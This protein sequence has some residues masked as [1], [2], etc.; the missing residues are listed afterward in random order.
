M[1]ARQVAQFAL[2]GV[3]T[4]AVVGLGT[5]IAARR[6]G[7]REAITEARATTVARAQGL[8][9]PVLTDGILTGDPDAFARVATVVRAGILD[10]SLVRV[11][12]WTGAGRIVYSDEPRLVGAT[13]RLGEDDLA[14]LRTGAIEAQVS[15]LT[16][17]ENRFER[18]F[19]RLLEVYLPVETPS[20][21]PLLFEA[22]YR[23]D[24]VVSSGARLFRAFA[25]I[26][27]GALVLLQL[28]QVPLAW[29]LARRL[30]RRVNERE[31]LLQRTLDAADVER[32]QIAS[33]LHDGVVQDLAGVAF[34]LSGASRQLAGD[35][36]LRAELLETAAEQVRGNIQALRSLLV[37]IYPPNLQDEGLETALTDLL[38]AVRTRGIRAELDASAFRVAVAPGV[39]Q[40]LYRGAQ[41]ALRNVVR[42]ADAT[43]VHVR[44]AAV[45]GS[46]RVEVTDDGRGFDREQAAARATEGH[47]GLRSLAGLVT[48]AGGTMHVA[49]DPDVGSTVTIEV[50]VA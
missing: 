18:P 5:A 38:A 39:A 44:L 10:D 16:Q 15:D 20:G 22:Y 46:A 21:E 35:D 43:S 49:S 1:V 31:A 42:H 27:L 41:E 13:Y 37:E 23:Y 8:L 6:V 34:S 12:L 28:V 32:R 14:S 2:A 45:D 19:G 48:D 30:R 40:L 26:A 47:L 9:A 24:A 29:S 4:V 17:P 50:P 36:P 11:K 33:D 7:E 25:P 3:I